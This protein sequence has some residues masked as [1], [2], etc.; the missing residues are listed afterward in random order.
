MA[1]GS[2]AF[3]KP[4]RLFFRFILR[5]ERA[6]TPEFTLAPY[7]PARLVTHGSTRPVFERHLYQP[8]ARTLLRGAR[9]VR[10]LQAGNLR[11]YLSYVLATLVI[12]L[13]GTR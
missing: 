13:L 4:I 2:T 5:P 1:Y 9:T 6:T 8:V 10:I 3:A 7:F 12:L 11:L